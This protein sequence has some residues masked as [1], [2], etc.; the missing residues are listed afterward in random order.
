MLNIIN[1]KNLNFSYDLKQIL[2]EIDF[3]VEKGSFFGLIGPNGSGKTTL[4]KIISGIL[5]PSSG[6]VYINDKNLNTFAR[7]SIA[8]KIAIVPQEI[9]IDFPFTVEEIVLMGRAPYLKHFS[10]EGE[11]DREIAKEAMNMT[12]TEK[13]RDRLIYELSGGERQRVIIARALAQMP[14]ILLLDEPTASLDIKYQIE[15]YN[16]LYKLNRER[17]ITVIVVSHDLN[18]INHYCDKILLLYEG[19]IKSLNTPHEVIT[20]KNIKEVYH[21]DVEINLSNKDGKKWILPL[22]N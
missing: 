10:F 13:F 16:L 14:E 6:H 21:I 19:V 20:K 22:M 2:T 9:K 4:L 5:S 12:D 8:K 7:K 11:N 17:K 18:L 15:I 1:I 3:S